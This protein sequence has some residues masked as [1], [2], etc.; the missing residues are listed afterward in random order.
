METAAL[1]C[2]VEQRSTAL[3][4]QLDS[5]ASLRKTAEGGCPHAVV[6]GLGA[7]LLVVTREHF[8]LGDQPI[9]IFVAC[10]VSTL[11]IEFIRATADLHFQ[12]GRGRVLVGFRR[13]G[14]RHGCYL[15]LANAS[16][17]RGFYAS[18]DRILLT[19]S[20]VQQ[21][22]ELMNEPHARRTPHK[23][24]PYMDCGG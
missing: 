9:L 24:G 16:V 8:L 1:G 11:F 17:S 10:R 21:R 7:L 22:T 4:W 18:H 19:H 14:R 6:D 12:V 5:G 2:P 23:R 13:V 15:L 20:Q 3:C